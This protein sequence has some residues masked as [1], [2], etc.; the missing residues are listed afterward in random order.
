MTA[1]GSIDYWSL[2]S[3]S[4]HIIWKHKF[5]WFFGFFASAGGG[6]GLNWVDDAG[7]RLH[8]FFFANPAILVLTIVGLVIVWL[9]LFV[10]NLISK[11]ALVAGTHEASEGRHVTFGYGWREGLRAFWRILGLAVLALIA[12]LFVTA[13][14]VIP[15][16]LALFGGTPGIVIAVVI[17]AVLFFPYLAFL[18]LLSFTVTYA[19]REVV[20]RR[21][22]IFDAIYAGWD[23]TKRHFW[24]SI[25]VW[26]IM[27][28]SALVFGISMVVVLL[29]LAVPFIL[30][31]LANVFAALVL[32]IPVG[33]AF[34][35]VASGAFGSYAYSV[36]TLAY[37]EL[38]KIGGPVGG[39]A[40][41]V[42]ATGGPS[43]GVPGVGVPGAGY[44]PAGSPSTGVLG[45]GDP[46]ADD[47]PTG[48]GSPDVSGA[49]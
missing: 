8:D 12:F 30:I 43:T 40:E 44:P 22:N 45:A 37:D 20:L 48:W 16:V 41:G 7:P 35:L 2:V 39:P 31:G 1:T 14:C 3:R 4:L 10:M 49:E 38:K 19:E 9:V 27:L 17:A 11:G 23:L 46:P 42:P 26:L 15:V 32:G 33:V 36:W 5:L 6:G 29:I 28:A 25:L 21:A 13:I 34:I 47:P 18:F 24:K